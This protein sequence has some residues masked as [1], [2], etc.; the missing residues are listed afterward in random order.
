VV[1]VYQYDDQD[2]VVRAIT[3]S[4]WTSEDRALMLARQANQKKLHERCGHPKDKAFH[5]DNE[6]WYDASDTLVCWA[7]T[8]LDQAADSKAPPHE[9]HV[10]RDVRDYDAKPLPPLSPTK[11]L[12]EQP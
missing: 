3:Q 11:G 8:A 6:G 4:E 2:R 10:I 5:P 1:T 7:C 12:G 9:M